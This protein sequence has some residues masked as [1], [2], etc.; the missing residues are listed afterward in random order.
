MWYRS[1]KVTIE[2][3]TG[4]IQDFN[5]AGVPVDQGSGACFI[6]FWIITVISVWKKIMKQAQACG[7]RAKPYAI[8][9]WAIQA[10]ESQYM[11]ESL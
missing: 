11:Y 3:E 1:P 4:R 6:I 9:F 2:C 7:S 10:Q 5:L 8:G